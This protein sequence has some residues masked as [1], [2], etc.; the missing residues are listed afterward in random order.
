M[1]QTK[2]I[3]G[4]TTAQGTPGAELAVDPTFLAARIALKPHEYAGQG[5]VLGHYG[6]CQQSGAVVNSTLL[7]LGHLGSIRWS[8]P[9]TYLVLLRIRVGC[10]IQT[11]MTAALTTDIRAIVARGFSVD[12]T[13]ASTAI[14]MAT[15]AKTNAMRSSMSNS[16]MG[17]NGPRICT[18]VVMSGQTFTADAAPFAVQYFQ[19]H[20]PTNVTGTVVTQSV[21]PTAPVTDLYNCTLNGQHPLVL[22]NNE[23]VILQN[24]T[25]GNADGK[26]TYTFGWEFAEVVVF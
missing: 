20:Y 1:A 7:A 5:K 25:A 15:P 17:I 13:T 23:G 10:N 19:L 8:D 12:F 26:I 24:I 22:S 3:G 9:S 6:V 11:I 2:I 21:G 4:G 18:T 16:L 14:N